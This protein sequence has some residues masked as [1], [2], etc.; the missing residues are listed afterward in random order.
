MIVA[1]APYEVTD[2]TISSQ[3]VNLKTAGADLLYDITIAK[4]ATQAIKKAAEISW[5]PV[6]ILV[7][8]A[9]WLRPGWKMPRGSSASGMERIRLIP[10]GTTIL[11][12]R[13]G[14]SS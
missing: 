5:K 9:L 6:H 1:E 7:F 4:F 11:T 10:P 8:G 12:R 14:A 2:P 13:N 3:I